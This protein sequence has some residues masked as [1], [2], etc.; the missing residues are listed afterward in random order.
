MFKANPYL[1]SLGALGVLGSVIFAASQNFVPDFVFKG[2][3]LTGWHK[4][5]AADWRAEKR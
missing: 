4:L 3:A 1:S 5:G 2:S